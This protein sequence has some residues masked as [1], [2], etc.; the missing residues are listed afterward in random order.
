MIQ[1]FSKLCPSDKCGVWTVGVFHLYKGFNRRSTCSG[2]FIKVSTKKVK[3]NNW[4]IKGSKHKSI[5]NLTKTN[6]VKNDGSK[7]KLKV[8][9]CV[10]LKKRITPKGKELFGPTIF[11]IRRKKFINSF[12]G[13]L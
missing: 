3:P 2:E 12:I 6:K 8:N 7:I 4:I 9:S 1:K 11:S 10:L 5:I 13:V